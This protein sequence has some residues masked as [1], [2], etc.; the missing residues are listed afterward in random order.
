M[1]CTPESVKMYTSKFYVFDHHHMYLSYGSSKLRCASVM[2]FISHF[3]AIAWLLVCQV[4]FYCHFLPFCLNC[5]LHYLMLGVFQLIMPCI[6]QI[7]CR[8]EQQKSF[9]GHAN[10][11]SWVNISHIQGLLV[12]HKMFVANDNRNNPWLNILPVTN[13]REDFQNSW[14]VVFL[15]MLFT[16]LNSEPI[17]CT[18]FQNN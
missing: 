6:G 16:C 17:C 14:I 1:K 4:C 9:I 11:K 2:L 15:K 7:C 3:Q 18:R 8:R 12:F 10:N 13:L 5:I